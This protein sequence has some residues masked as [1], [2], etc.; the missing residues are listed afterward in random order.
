MCLSVPG[1]ELYRFLAQAGFEIAT[2]CAPFHLSGYKS[3]S[4]GRPA[5]SVRTGCRSFGPSKAAIHSLILG[6][7]EGSPTS[8]I[9]MASAGRPDLS[10]VIK[11]PP[12]LTPSI[13]IHR[14]NSGKVCMILFRSGLGCTFRNS[15]ARSRMDLYSTTTSRLVLRRLIAARKST[16]VRPIGSTVRSLGGTISAPAHQ[17]SESLT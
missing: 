8:K 3:S 12:R 4:E 13:D 9:G 5:N 17:A 15:S 1:S 2:F 10:N 16:T 14:H 7:G 11:T 6:L